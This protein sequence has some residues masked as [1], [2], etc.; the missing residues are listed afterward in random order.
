MVRRPTTSRRCTS[1]NQIVAALLAECYKSDVDTPD[2]R[3]DTNGTPSGTDLDPA[4]KQR[5]RSVA[6]TVW[7]AVRLGAALY[8]LIAALQVIKTGAGAVDVF[9]SGGFLVRNAGSTFGL[10]WIGAMLTLSGSTA[11]AAALTLRAT[12]SI[13]E[14]QGFTMVTGARLGAA[15]V[16]L[17]IAAIYA[18]RS[19]EG[20]RLAPVSTAVMALVITAIIYLPGA[21]IGFFVLKGP[22]QSLS[23]H[24]PPSFGNLVNLLY[25]WMLNRI[26]TWP[27]GVL[28]VGGLVLLLVAF[29]AVDTLVP[30]VDESRLQG[31]RATWLRR[32]WPMFL[33]G[34]VVVIATLSV[35][36][37]LTVL[38]PLVAKGYVKREDLIPYIVGADLGTL[39]D[40]LLVAF[41]V[42]VGPG[43]THSASPVRI[44]LSEISGTAC[45][46]L[47]I[48]LFFYKP[49]KRFVWRFQRQMVRSRFRLGVFTATL[50][51]VPLLILLISGIVG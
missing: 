4:T 6:T 34:I 35:S 33:L 50:L 9:N 46:G 45:I 36:V 3:L 40:K 13:T 1:L 26:G 43:V 8:V 22:M 7:R 37:A 32:K 19:G 30:E 28:F 47:I 39:V 27:P 29:K 5:Q 44:I 16:V 42:G 14:I 15:F 41:L 2:A 38:V 24:A 21:L 23:L 48:M 31:S 20:K 11:A 18:V 25:G 49:F 51:A 12:G 10:G 17:L